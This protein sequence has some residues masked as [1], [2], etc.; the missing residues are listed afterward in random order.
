MEE[1]LI[2]PLDS[3]G[4]KSCSDGAEQMLTM[5][6]WCILHLSSIYNFN[7][8][9]RKN[10]NSNKQMEKKIQIKTTEEKQDQNQIKSISKA[11]ELIGNN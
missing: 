8:L 2:L 9:K 7:Y 11:D 4:V 10:S 3:K 5:P 6:V 1:Y